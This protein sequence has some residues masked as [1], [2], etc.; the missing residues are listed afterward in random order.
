ME[1]DFYATI[2]LVSGEE[3]FCSVCPFF[4]EEK[5][6]LLLDNP[7]II[8]PIQSKSSKIVGYK[9]SP[10]INISDDEMHIIE[11]KN[12]ITITEV[13]KPEIISIYQ[14]FTKNT[15]KLEVTKE[16]GLLSKVD[17]A[18]SLLEKIYNT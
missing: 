10:W 8:I 7:V 2:K 13:N 6:F 4:E 9:V 11:M 1:D 15:S 17:E 5:T 3:I 14:K 18:R 12:V 16:M